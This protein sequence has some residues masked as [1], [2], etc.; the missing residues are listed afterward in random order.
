MHLLAGKAQAWKAGKSITAAS[1]MGASEAGRASAA[2]LGTG[3]GTGAGWGRAES[4][5]AEQ[6]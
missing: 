5:S 1:G 2:G 4:K 6:G 3:M